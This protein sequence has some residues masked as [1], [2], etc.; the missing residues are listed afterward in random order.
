MAD[1]EGKH[2]PRV[3]SNINHVKGLKALGVTLPDRELP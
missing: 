2:Y 1:L 3:T